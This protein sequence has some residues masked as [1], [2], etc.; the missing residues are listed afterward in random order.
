MLYYRRRGACS[1]MAERLT[2][3]QEVVGSKP[4][5][6]PTNARHTLREEWNARQ[7]RSSLSGIRAFTPFP[8]DAG[9]TVLR[10]MADSVDRR[11]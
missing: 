8:S 4:I 3:A 7:G 1:S 11:T 5:R 6:H 9:E 2:V 10:W